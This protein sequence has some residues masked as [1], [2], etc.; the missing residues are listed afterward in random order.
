MGTGTCKRPE[1]EA[2][3][4]SERVGPR[5]RRAQEPLLIK[6]LHSLPGQRAPRSDALEPTPGVV[7]K[8]MRAA[9]LG[10]QRALQPRCG[11]TRLA[12]RAN[13][14]DW[15]AAAEREARAHR[16]GK[17]G[18]GLSAVQRHLMD[19]LDYEIKGEM[20]AQTVRLEERLTA[21]VVKLTALRVQAQAE[22]SLVGRYNLERSTALRLAHELSVQREAATGQ[23]STAEMQKALNM[24]RPL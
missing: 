3:P 14:G 19:S 12:V 4:P 6:F 1:Q 15:M 10:L 24:P 18:D 17:G 23:A 16:P 9:V 22:S 11:S 5:A 13:H 7:L 21:A 8:M 2:T 20:M